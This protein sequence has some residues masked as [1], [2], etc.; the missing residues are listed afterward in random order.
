MEYCK[1]CVMPETKPGLTLDNK[2]VCSA[3]RSVEKKKEIDWKERKKELLELCETVKKN[4]RGPYDCIVAVSGG[5]DSI[6]M[7]WH[8]KEVCKMRVLCVCVSEHLKTQEGIEN[9][10]NMIEKL[11][12]DTI[13]ISL[14]PST[15]KALRKKTFNELGE[16]NWA[17]HCA[18]FSGG[19]P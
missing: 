16:P 15:H 9:L 3:C 13:V 4:N 12:I 2:G 10:N 14:K 18:V 11:G 19:F 5:K 17:E 1:R 6:Y 7:A 8:M